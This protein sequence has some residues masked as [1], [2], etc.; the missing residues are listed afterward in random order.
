MS[1][2]RGGRDAAAARG[3]RSARPTRSQVFVTTGGFIALAVWTGLILV[4]GVLTF[5]FRAPDTAVA[6]HATS[7]VVS[8]LT[9]ALAYLRFSLTRR[10]TFLFVAV[11][12]SVLATN[13]FVFGIL[14]RR[15]SVDLETNAYL[16]VLGRLIT[17]AFLLAGAFRPSD[18]RPGERSA[19][20]QF[21]RLLAVG[22]ATL[23]VGQT[24]ILASRGSLPPLVTGSTPLRR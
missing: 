1:A 23:A 6:I 17:A 20:A 7:A 9:A 5:S 12:F 19:L 22:L 14:F 8:A 3:V 21:I 13:Q 10:R 18:E 4:V 16:W 24:L 15:G 2:A 11:A